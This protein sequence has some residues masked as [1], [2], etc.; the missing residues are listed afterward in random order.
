[1]PTEFE[2]GL[3]TGLL[4]GE[5]HFGGDGRQPQVTLRMHVRHEA[6]FRWLERTFPGGKLYGPYSHDGRNYY[7]WMA[8]GS[9]LRERLLPVL[10]ESLS[11][12]LDGPSY[13]R[14]Q[15][16]V[17]RYARRLGT[18]PREAASDVP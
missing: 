12:E 4:M 7:Q 15:A 10:T 8:R 17:E 5:G 6:I 3:L 1:M 18:S 13:Q 16:M 9:Y 14:F 11:P 2:R